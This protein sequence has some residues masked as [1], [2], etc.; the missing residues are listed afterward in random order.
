MK[1]TVLHKVGVSS[2]LQ[3]YY[4]RTPA[5]VFSCEFSEIFNNM[6]FIEYL[7]TSAFGKNTLSSFQTE[8]CANVQIRC[9]GEKLR[10]RG[11]AKADFYDQF[12][13][14]PNFLKTCFRNNKRNSIKYLSV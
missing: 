1:F 2:S 13:N 10:E 6:F 4:K 8:N 9:A 14:S 7:W 3:N 12:I 11:A 5:E